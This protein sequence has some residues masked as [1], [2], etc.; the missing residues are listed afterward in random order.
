MIKLLKKSCPTQFKVLEANYKNDYMAKKCNYVMAG[1]VTF[2]TNVFK[3]VM[4]CFGEN[5]ARFVKTRT[6]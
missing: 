4:C 5:G 1:I 3:R 2:L 6:K